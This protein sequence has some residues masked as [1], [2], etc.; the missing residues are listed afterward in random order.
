MAPCWWSH[1]PIHKVC[2]PFLTFCPS[3][4]LFLENPTTSD[5]CRPRPI[6][7][8]VPHLPPRLHPLMGTHRSP[9]LHRPHPHAHP[10]HPPTLTSPLAS[11][12]QQSTVVATVIDR[13]VSAI[14]TIKAFNTIPHK[15]SHTDAAFHWLDR[16]AGKLTALGQFIM[17]F[18]F[19]SKLVREDNIS[20]GDVMAVF[21]A[22]LI[23]TSDTQMRIS[24][25]II[26][27]KGIF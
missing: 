13:V 4:M 23:A 27:A 11:E 21:W 9:S 14:S 12:R 20:A 26:H 6:P 19:G 1:G 25:F 16:A 17:S 22:Y 3:P 8:N 2:L 15:L 5:S 18:W 10:R 24:Q 7:N